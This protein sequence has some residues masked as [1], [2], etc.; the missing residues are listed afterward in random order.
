MGDKTIVILGGY[1]LAGQALAHYLLQ[2]TDA[3][4]ILAGRN[5]QKATQLAADLNG[6]FP[7]Q[8]V[9][10]KRADAADA[11]SLG[12]ALQGADLA[13]VASSTVAYTRE[14]AAAALAA[15]VDYLDI[16]YGEGR[17]PI[18][19]SLA[20]EIDRSALCFVTEA[21]FHPGLPAAMVRY[22]GQKTDRLDQAVVATMLNQQGGLPYTSGVDEL[23]QEFKDYKAE[24]FSGGAWRNADM[25]TMKDNPTMDFGPPF[26]RRSCTP[27]TLKEMYNLPRMFP[28]LQQLGFYVAGFNWFA[29][30]VVM[31]LIMVA[32]RI[33]PTRS[34][35]P[36]GRLLCWATRAFASPPYGVIV[37]AEARGMKD[38]QPVSLK[39][40]ISHAD[41]YALTAMPVVAYLLQYLDGSAR[42]PGLHLMGHLADPARLFADMARMGATIEE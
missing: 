42:R 13:L 15:H 30:W 2:E 7:G 31:P 22:L 11:E 23:V 35:K 14:V 36:M 8:R 29:D 24:V 10:A 37:R 32:L 38:G 21:G 34:V 1:G 16:L 4:L 9:A 40:A 5:E 20:A 39:L 18:L 41:G 27:M 19:Q 26:G 33:A 28:T 6:R 17:L 25:T 12:Q 3:H